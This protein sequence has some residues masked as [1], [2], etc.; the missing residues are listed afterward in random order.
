M[1]VE[2][3]L[4]QGT[5]VKQT[6]TL[7][8]L[9]ASLIALG[10]ACLLP[11]AYA[12]F[13]DVY[14]DPDLVVSG[15]HHN[16]GYSEQSYSSD[17]SVTYYDNDE[18]Q[19]YDD[20]A[21]NNSCGLNHFYGPSF[22]FGFS[23][24]FFSFGWGYP[25]YGYSPYYGYYPY[26]NWCSSNYYYG[27]NNY[28]GGCNSYYSYPYY[29]CGYGNCGGYGSCGGYGGYYP[30]YYP[31]GSNGIYYGPRTAGNTGSSPRGPIHPGFVQPVYES[32]SPD[33]A[34][35]SDHPQVVDHGTTPGGVNNPSP[36][37]PGV[38]RT[39]GNTLISNEGKTTGI[40]KD[41]PVDRELTRGTT[42]PSPQKPVF[43]P[44]SERFKPYPTN[45]PI[46][47]TTD[48]PI[49]DKPAINP[50]VPSGNNDSPGTTPERSGNANSGDE[51]RPSDHSD[52]GVTNDMPDYHPQQR[53]PESSH[54]DHQSTYAP[55]S[56]HDENRSNDRPSYSPPQ[57]SND[58]GSNHE[59]S[60]SSSSS[61]GHYS[62]G[63]GGGH[64]ESSHG[65]PSHSSGGGG[66]S[67]SSGGGGSSH[68]SGS[69]PRS[70]GRG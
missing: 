67:H 17:D 11:T 59:R 41:L 21:G 32:K 57:R 23:F 63:G 51:P 27:Y 38:D 68:S 9:K 16:S 2:S 48:R 7:Y 12:Q 66:S 40:T 34:K 44:F 69:S 53:D 22:G 14:Y 70:P 36:I 55:S 6:M 19:Y 35:N 54:T 64:S 58:S 50:S 30:P 15:Y 42:T 61:G 31:G 1:D 46:T 5:N 52:P 60:G 33:V 3:F 29:G 24:P 28:W 62:S 26:N 65:S 4:P 49:F 45:D 18:Y 8:T 10:L 20:Y 13:D 37:Q 56:R 39:F 25:Y 43:K 47:S